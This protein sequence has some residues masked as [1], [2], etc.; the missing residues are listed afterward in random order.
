MIAL[1]A[2]IRRAWNLHM[3]AKI[4]MIWRQKPWPPIERGRM[5]FIM[6]ID[7]LK[8]FRKRGDNGTTND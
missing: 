1:T 6:P 4:G 2:A 7:H 3:K 8:P 5:R